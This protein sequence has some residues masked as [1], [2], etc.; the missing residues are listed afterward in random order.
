MA[1]ELA[2]IYGED[3]EK[4]YLAGLVHDCTKNTPPEIQLEIME[5]G[6]S[7]DPTKYLT[8]EEK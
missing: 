7:V 5:N 8:L 2:L 3:P 1:K 6:V 4:A